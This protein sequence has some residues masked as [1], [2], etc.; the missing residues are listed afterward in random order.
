MVEISLSGSGEGPG[1]TTAPGYSTTA[2][3]LVSES[4]RYVRPYGGPAA[5]LP[6]ECRVRHDFVVGRRVEFNETT[7]RRGSVQAV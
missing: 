4:R 3:W 1:W 2:F 7:Q 6:V 5:R